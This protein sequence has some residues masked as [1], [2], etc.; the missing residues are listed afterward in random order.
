MRTWPAVLAVGLCLVV[1]QDSKAG[2][3]DKPSEGQTPPFKVS[4]RKT[5][6][7]AGT[8]AE[9][10]VVVFSLKCPSGIGQAVIE[11]L[12]EK[13]PKTV[14]VYLNLKGL[15]HLQVANGKDTLHATMRTVDGQP[16]MRQG[17]GDQETERLPRTDPLWMNICPMAAD[18]KPATQLPL[19]NGYFEITLPPAFFEGNPK[20]VSLHWIDHDREK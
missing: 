15:G 1:G 8:W 16:R 10:E 18:G 2:D 14:V 11:R 5:E 6:D 20:S 3:T 13:W 7:T 19:V 9:G 12:G 4:L 17:K